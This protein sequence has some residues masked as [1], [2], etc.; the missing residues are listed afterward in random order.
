MTGDEQDRRRRLPRPGSG[1]RDPG[2]RR[3]ARGELPLLACLTVVVALLAL[4]TAAGPPLLD[5]WAGDAL[6]SRFDTA[7]QTDAEIRH[8]VSL[9][10]DDTEPPPDPATATVGRDLAKVTAGLLASAG[11]PLSSVLVHDSTRVEV[12]VLGAAL[13]AGRL[14]LGLLYADD[15][16]AAA[17]YPQGGPPGP[18]G[19]TSPI[20]VAFSTL[21]RD[22]LHL[23]L[24]QRFHL[25]P[26]VG[27]FDTDA[28]VSG[29]FTPPADATAPLWHEESLLERPARTDGLWHAQAVIDAASIDGLQQ[30]T[31][32]Q[33]HDLVVQWRSSIRM[34]PDQATRFAT[35]GGLRRLQDAADSYAAAADQDF[36]PEPDGYMATGCRIGRHGTTELTTVDDIPDLIEPFARARGQARTLESFALA[37]LIAVG[38]A[39]VVVT[40]RLAVHRRAAAQ[41]LQQARGAS[42]TDLALVRLV[43]TA[44][45]AL[46][47]LALGAGAARLAAPPGD[48]PGGLVP[49]LVV[50]AVAWL[51]LPALTLVATRDRAGRAGR[52]PAVRRVGVEAAVLLLAAAGVLLL[53][54]HGAGA[55]GLDVGLAVVPALL[56]TATVVL[57]IRVYPLPLR[58]LSRAARARRGTVPLVALSRA[59]REAPGHALALLVLVTTLSTAVFGGLV[60]RT[61]ADGSRTAAVWSSGA[62]AVVIGAGRDGTPERTLADVTGVR[63]ATVVRSLVNQL[64]SDRDGARYGATRVV[65]VDAGALGTAAHGSAAARA[66]AAAGLA[67]RPA[68]AA[69][70]G[71]Y[72]L[73]ALATADFAGGRPGDT[74]TTT[75]RSGTVSFRVV[76]VLPAA[77]RRDPALGPLLSVQQRDA[78]RG[79]S[80]DSATAVAAGSPLLLVDSAEL[81]MLEA[82]EFHDSAVL[83]YGPRL[84]T[85]SLRAAGPRVTG[86]SGEVRVKATAMALAADDG[87]LRSVR[88]TY[89]T[90][91]ALSVL[92]AL[93][94]LVLELLLSSRD[95]GRTASRLRT[96][97]LPTRGIAAMNVL[98]LLPMVLAA[99]AGGV[100]LGLVLPG[101]LGPT[102]TLR[103]FTGGP[104]APA[105][106]DDHA[107]TAGLGLGLAALVAAAVA[108]ETWAG[109]R[110]GLGAVL[111]LGDAV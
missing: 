97:G 24:G 28:V 59:A 82:D 26:A 86:P 37:G 111:R 71:H 7:R 49:A 55:G 50:A 39:T 106:H 99:V 22:T 101:I 48:G 53:R 73:P 81:T 57:L 40:A 42:A 109:R 83:F 95:R 19:R 60:A 65:A 14:E 45:A 79:E 18:P 9:H 85:A 21:A 11:P 94:A 2:L 87:L 70:G 67:G 16:P 74:Y 43:Q 78:G 17:S 8:S 107:L 5:R 98:E 103:E 13:P 27:T 68:P 108:A 72:V 6:R 38:L 25:S 46:L 91:T 20:P 12:P 35:G 51:T 3:E 110:R 69:A 56:G 104:G 96:L 80:A 31:R 61:V 34:T 66:L 77:V 93:V 64:T 47:G 89:A 105:L 84:D 30:V 44:P 62:D 102:L 10:R 15:A 100:A 63:R 41:A 29:F 54:A 92:L 76:G 36:C 58:L 88:R 90:T 75:L 32:G 52:P 4:I 33:G 1:V 23:G